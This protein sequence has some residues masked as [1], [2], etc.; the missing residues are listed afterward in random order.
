MKDLKIPDHQ[1]IIDNKEYYELLSVKS[2]FEGECSY[3]IKG[4]PE[5]SVFT[6]RNPNYSGEGDYYKHTFKKYTP[7]SFIS[8]NEAVIKLKEEINR[9]NKELENIKQKHKQAIEMLN[10]KLKKSDKRA[11]DVLSNI[12]LTVPVRQ[13]KQWKKEERR[14]KPKI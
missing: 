4:E 9:L 12:L 5:V 1:V 10:Q 14:K 11:E 2:A 3:I 6:T 7:I 8:N 13:F